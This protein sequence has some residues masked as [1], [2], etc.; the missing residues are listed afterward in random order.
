MKINTASFGEIEVDDKQQIYFP[1]GII[2]F[3][4]YKNYV[5]LDSE[6]EHFYILQSLDQVK[7]SFILIN[8]Y[9][10]RSDYVLEILDADLAE[11]G[12][13][14]PQKLLVFSIVTLPNDITKISCNLLGPILINKKNL[15]GRQ[16]I[17]LGNWQTKHF[18]FEKMAQSNKV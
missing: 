10:V 3:E 4:P 8:P 18:F 11:I 1:A 12:C 16:S 15:L 7:N 5:L 6:K 17:S 9:L 14:D 13:D 2:G